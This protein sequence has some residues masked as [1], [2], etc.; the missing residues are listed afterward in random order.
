MSPSR[1]SLDNPQFG[2]QEVQVFEGQLSGRVPPSSVQSSYPGLRSIVWS[3]AL[4]R[5][6]PRQDPES[7]FPGKEGFGVQKP[8]FPLKGWEKGVFGPKIQFSVCS[9]V[10]KRGFF[11]RKLPFP[12]RGEMGVFGPRNPLFHEMGIRAPLWGRGIP[13][14][15]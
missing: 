5:F 1:D 11:D 3:K 12:K 13:S 6:D 8:Q 14:F 10:E 15:D 7:P 2:A 9:L 4:L